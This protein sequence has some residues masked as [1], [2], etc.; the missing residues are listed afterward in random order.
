M[1]TAD[2]H[3]HDHSTIGNEIIGRMNAFTLGTNFVL[4]LMWAEANQALTGHSWRH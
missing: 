4:L 2:H 1:L 3:R